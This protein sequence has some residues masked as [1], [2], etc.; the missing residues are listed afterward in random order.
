MRYNNIIVK[1]E[2]KAQIN[3]AET[4]QLCH[5]WESSVMYVNERAMFSNEQCRITPLTKWLSQS[6]G[7]WHWEQ[8]IRLQSI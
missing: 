4:S 5:Y 1:L 8:A 2:L 6:I 7:R 3:H